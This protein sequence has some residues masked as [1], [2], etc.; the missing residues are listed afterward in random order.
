VHIL[1][2]WNRKLIKHIAF[3]ETWLDQQLR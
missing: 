3:N 1:Y 2:T